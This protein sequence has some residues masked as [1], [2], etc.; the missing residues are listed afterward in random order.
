MIQLLIFSKM[1]GKTRRDL[2][3]VYSGVA[4]G[5]GGTGGN[6]PPLTAKKLPKIGKRGKNQEKLG[7]KRKNREEKAKIGKVLSLSPS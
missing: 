6:V 2:N 4:T 1:C 5:E 3:T 7:K